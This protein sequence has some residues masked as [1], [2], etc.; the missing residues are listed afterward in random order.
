VLQHI[1]KG[2]I[3]HNYENSTNLKLQS[4]AEQMPAL[5]A[6]DFYAS[7]YRFKACTGFRLRHGFFVQVFTRT[8]S[9]DIDLQR[10]RCK[11]LQ[12]N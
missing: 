5:V 4:T 1:T 9:Y 7:F 12:R 8:Q 10:R 6:M 2:Q 11:K 3:V